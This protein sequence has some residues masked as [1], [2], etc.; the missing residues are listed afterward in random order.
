MLMAI[1]SISVIIPNFNGKELLEKNLPYV[2]LALETSH[3]SDFEIIITDDASTDDSV[4]F[5]QKFYQNKIIL[6][7]NPKNLGFS[8][9][10]NR[11]IFKAQKELVFI[12]NSDVQLTEG[13]FKPLF[14][15]FDFENTFGV[16]S[17]IVDF[18]NQ[19]IDQAKFPLISFSKID[20]TKNFY[21]PK[22][23]MHY[24]LFLSGANA[25]IER[26]K[27]IELGGFLEIYNPFYYEDVDLGIRAWRKGYNCYYNHEAVCKHDVSS[28]IKTKNSQWVQII[29]QRNKIYLHFLHLNDLGFAVFML[30]FYFKIFID[31]ILFKKEKLK[32]FQEFLKNFEKLSKIKKELLRTSQ[33]NLTEVRNIIMSSKI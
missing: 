20:G 25:L 30:K 15:Y 17:K 1:K 24:T 18:K 14:S 5:L 28:T 8:G 6:I 4:K 22:H 16:M 32:A 9:N 21:N 27:L 23:L 26:K 7:E 11:A 33:R 2:F 13:Y 10:V 31:L 3:V 19:I 12:L 29:V